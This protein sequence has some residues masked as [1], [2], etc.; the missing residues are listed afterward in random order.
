[1]NNFDLDDYKPH[2]VI[3]MYV[4]SI[5]CMAELHQQSLFWFFSPLFGRFFNIITWSLFIWGWYLINNNY[6]IKMRQDVQYYSLC[7]NFS[8]FCHQHII[9]W[10]F[11]VVSIGLINSIDITSCTMQ[12]LFISRLYFIKSNVLLAWGDKADFLL[13]ADNS[14][15]DKVDTSDFDF[16]WR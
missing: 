16:D 10:L 14:S 6:S 7:C 12:L 5:A 9:T 8:D 15:V 3:G 11:I 2:N 4:A 13:L 1:M